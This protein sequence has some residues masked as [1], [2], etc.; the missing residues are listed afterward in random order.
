MEVFV[1]RSLGNC[2][3]DNE[4]REDSSPAGRKSEIPDPGWWGRERVGFLMRRLD[5]ACCRFGH[6]R[7]RTS[8]KDCKTVLNTVL[9]FVLYDTVVY[10][11]VLCYTYF[12]RLYRPC[13]AVQ[14]CAVLYCTVQYCTV[15]NSVVLHYTVPCS[16]V[17]SCIKL[18]CYNA[19]HRVVLCYT[20]LY[21]I[22][23]C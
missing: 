20:V 2:N 6:S 4:K 18:L 7:S 23:M 15:L 21:L 8:S 12:T 1:D 17:L 10:Y 13:H 3:R 14:Y 11:I 5:K 16:S 22:S 19:Q 9:Y